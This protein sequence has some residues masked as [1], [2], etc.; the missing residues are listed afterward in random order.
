MKVA[1]VDSYS[2]GG[3]ARKRTTWTPFLVHV[4]LRLWVVRVASQT[5]W[6]LVASGITAAVIVAAV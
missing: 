3:L 4:D 5:D 2:R 1:R 6:C